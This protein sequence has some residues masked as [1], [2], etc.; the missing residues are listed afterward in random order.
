MPTVDLAKRFSLTN[1]ERQV[2]QYLIAGKSR[3]E[4]AAEM[5][6]SEDTVR[7]YLRSLYEKLGVRSQVEAATLGL[8]MELVENL[9]SV[10]QVQ[11]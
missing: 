4:I 9:K 8:R 11:K 10:L 6:L 3:K 2:L 7:S 5:H 1:R